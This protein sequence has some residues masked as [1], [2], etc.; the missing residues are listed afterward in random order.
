VTRSLAVATS[1]VVEIEVVTAS[2]V[3]EVIQGTGR[4]QF[5]IAMSNIFVN[6]ACPLLRCL[7]RSAAPLY[8]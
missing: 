3:L 4:V 6:F 5:V 8:R 1:D 7:P 2:Y